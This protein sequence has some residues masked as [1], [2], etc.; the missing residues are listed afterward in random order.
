MGVGLFKHGWVGGGGGG[1]VSLD[2]WDGGDGGGGPVSLSTVVFILGAPQRGTLSFF[3]K[4][5]TTLG[6]FAG[7]RASTIQN[8]SPVFFAYRQ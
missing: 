5:P 1:R 7:N 3:W 6:W 4:S 2:A 8:Y